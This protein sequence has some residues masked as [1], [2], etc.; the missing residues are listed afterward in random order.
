MQYHVW[1]FFTSN[2]DILDTQLKIYKPKIEDTSSTGH[3][4]RFTQPRARMV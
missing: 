1:E 2:Y 4:L 3:T